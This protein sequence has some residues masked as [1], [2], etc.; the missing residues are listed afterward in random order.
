VGW[1]AMSAGCH[2][3]LRD[4][5]AIL[6][7][8]ADDIEAMLTSFVEHDEPDAARGSSNPTPEQQAEVDPRT[9]EGRVLAALS[10]RRAAELDRLVSRTG[11]SPT[12]VLVALGLLEAQGLA[13]R[14]DQG[15][16]GVAA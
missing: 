6:V 8:C 7:T 5:Q 16:R 15:W 12:D 1:R 13:H 10:H 9:R 14:G 2:D 4:R 11:L 3:L